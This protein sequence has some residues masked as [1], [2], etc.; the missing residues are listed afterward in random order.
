[1]AEHLIPD[2]PGGWEQTSLAE[3]CEITAGPS[4]TVLRADRYTDSVDGIPVVM[5]KD[6]GDN[7]LTDQDLSRIPAEA[8]ASLLRFRL[9]PGDIV[10]SRR[11]SLGRRALVRD[12][13][14]GWLFGT[15]C[16]RVRVRP[17]TDPRFVSYYLGH[18]NVRT[19]LSG[20][21]MG[22]TI[23]SISAKVLGDLPLSLPPVETQR[24]IGELLG[25]LDARIAANEQL[26][27]GI[28]KLRD[29]LLPRLLAGEQQI[30]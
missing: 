24:A 18:P 16:L 6:I 29:A 7:V 19:W 20:N 23:P 4:G 15:G 14:D 9:R 8:A 3:V 2:V 30:S 27:R 22:S 11:G 1:M 13:N 26:N 21:A 12:E 25:S 17:Q 28:S 5:P 10:C